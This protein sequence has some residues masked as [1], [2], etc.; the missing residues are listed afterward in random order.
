MNKCWVC[1]AWSAHETFQQRNAQAPSQPSRSDSLGV[2]VELLFLSF[3][4]DPDLEPGCFASVG[5]ILKWDVFKNG[6]TPVCSK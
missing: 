4:C 5:K 1:T 6:P 3:P 2:T